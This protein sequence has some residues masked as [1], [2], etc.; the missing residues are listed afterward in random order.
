MSIRG[1]ARRVASVLLVSAAA[2]AVSLAAPRPAAARVNLNINFFAGPPAFSAVRGTPVYYT[3]QLDCDLYRYGNDYYACQDGLWYRS[4]RL[5][6]RFQPIAAYAVPRIV[7]DVS[8][9]GY[10]GGRYDGYGHGSYDR[11]GYRYGR[12]GY[13]GGN[14][15]GRG[16]YDRGPGY[17]RVDEWRQ[18]QQRDGADGRWQGGRDGNNQGPSGQW[19]R[20]NGNGS[21]QGGGGDGQWQ[22]R[23]RDGRDRDQAQEGRD[24]D[25]DRGDWNGG[26][27]R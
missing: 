6:G 4:R 1:K 14:G 24:R 10:R 9:G 23:N 21:W 13:G 7:L 15:Y 18:R 8:F 16:G 19:Q 12:A 11:G 26:R 25:D 2:L 20:G 17:L 27:N 22:G 3:D 5:P